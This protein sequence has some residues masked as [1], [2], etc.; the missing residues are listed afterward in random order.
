MG[1]KAGFRRLPGRNPG[2][3]VVS[4]VRHGYDVAES[5]RAPSGRVKLSIH[6]HSSSSGRAHSTCQV[7]PSESIEYGPSTMLVKCYGFKRGACQ[8]SRLCIGRA[9]SPRAE[10]KRGRVAMLSA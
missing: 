4:N 6:L 10:S 3:V 9:R 2:N 1:L 8:V 7:E 5:L